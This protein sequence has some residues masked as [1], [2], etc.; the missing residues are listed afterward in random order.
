M[1]PM[2]NL[3]LGNAKG[4]FG[5]MVE[6]EIL[7]AKKLAQIAANLQSIHTNSSKAW[8]PTNIVSNWKMF[9]ASEW[10]SWTLVYSLQALKGV[11]PSEYYDAWSKFVVACQLISK[12]S[13]TQEEI[14]KADSLFQ[15]YMQDL[16]SDSLFGKHAIKPN[17][18]MSCHLKECIED[19]GPVH[20]YWLFAFERINGY[21]GDYHTNF[22]AIEVTLMRKFLSDRELATRA[23]NLPKCFH[24]FCQIPVTKMCSTTPKDIVKVPLEVQKIAELPKVDCQKLWSQFPH[25]TMPKKVDSCDLKLDYLHRFDEDDIG[26]LHKTYK[27]MYNGA[28]ITAVPSLVIRFDTI[29]IGSEVF[30]AVNKAQSTTCFILANWANE[31]GCIDETDTSVRLGK[32]KYFFKHNITMPNGSTKSHIMCTVQWYE[33]LIDSKLPIG[34]AQPVKVFRN[35]PLQAGPA[36]FMPV[37]RIKSKC[38]FSFRTV[39]GYR[40]CIVV[41][42]VRFDVFM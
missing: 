8:L 13:V 6:N 33:E 14:E 21:L 25:V 27:S 34:Y 30:R 32:I 41:S 37:Q 15:A 26:L 39:N 20:S 4:F 9:N 35:R 36:T 24:D 40:D 18:H 28:F 12:P 42:P 31:D 23:M 16:Q 11:I 7:D 17:N 29:K 38:A 19:F 10:K 2:H 3:Y 1:D 5:Q 22:K